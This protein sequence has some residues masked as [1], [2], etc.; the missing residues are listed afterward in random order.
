MPDNFVMACLNLFRI[1]HVLQVYYVY[2][3]LSLPVVLKVA[4]YGEIMVRPRFFDK[5]PPDLRGL[6]HQKP[7]SKHDFTL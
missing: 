2:I 3:S 7:K 6:I 5:R 4:E 1:D